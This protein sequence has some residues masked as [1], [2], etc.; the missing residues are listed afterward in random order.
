KLKKWE[1][2]NILI[3]FYNPRHLD[4]KPE[5]TLIADAIERKLF[6]ESNT[7]NRNF[8]NEVL[9]TGGA[10]LND[11]MLMLSPHII[12]KLTLQIDVVKVNKCLLI[13]NHKKQ[14]Y[15]D[16][17]LSNSYTFPAA[18]LQ[19]QIIE[20]SHNSIIGNFIYHFI[21]CSEEG[22]GEKFYVKKEKK[23]YVLMQDNKTP[24]R[25]NQPVIKL[26]DV[27]EREMNSFDKYITELK[28][29]LYSTKIK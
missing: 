23:G 19:G 18:M 1:K 9:T 21:P 17:Q 28:N 25:L 24:Y 7:K 22:N 11:V 2:S 8:I 3:R 12:V 27:I 10:E 16:I 13:K 20:N 14:K 6:M 26:Y 29:K 5:E 15:R 4:E